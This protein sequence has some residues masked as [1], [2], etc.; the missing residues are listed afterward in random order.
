MPVKASGAG[1]VRAMTANIVS[2]Y[3]SKNKLRADDLAQLIQDVFSA[4][5]RASTG[6][7]APAAS[8]SPAVPIKQSVTRHY[9]V[10]LEDGRKLKTLKGHLR[11]A[12]DMTPEQ[13]REKWQL[14][15]DY[16]MVAPSYSKRRSTLAKELGLGKLNRP[17]RK[18]KSKGRSSSRAKNRA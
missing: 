3:A 18:R 6:R 2:A 9:I 17:D 16:P 7:P 5:D 1:N 10:C 14:P 12:F 4:L 13:Y 15:T 11:S 8:Q